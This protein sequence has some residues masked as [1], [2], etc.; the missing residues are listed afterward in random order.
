MTR[1]D[2][3]RSRHPINTGGAPGGAA[4]AR[5]ASHPHRCCDARASRD[6][7]AIRSRWHADE[8]L[9]KVR[10]RVPRKHSGATQVV[11]SPTCDYSMPISGNPEIGRAP[12]FASSGM[13][14]RDR[15][16]RALMQADASPC[17]QD[18][19]RDKS[20]LHP[21]RHCERKRSNPGFP[22][23]RPAPKQRQK[24]RIALSLR[25]SQGQEALSPARFSQPDKQRLPR[26][27]AAS[28]ARLSA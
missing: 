28:Q 1:R 27:F 6:G 22:I 26:R 13:E 21:R 24:N 15:A 4:S 16:V 5:W 11:V 10:Q 17:A 19:A 3:S 23:S 12:L 14:N 2:E 9:A 20:G 25:S 8:P 18:E 7:L